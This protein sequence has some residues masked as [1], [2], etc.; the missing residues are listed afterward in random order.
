MVAQS[1]PTVADT[2]ICEFTV[3]VAWSWVKKA[4][5]FHSLRLFVLAR[6]GMHTSVMRKIMSLSPGLFGAF[7]VDG[8]KH[9]DFLAILILI[10][11]DK[12]H[13]GNLLLGVICKL[14]LF[15]WR[16]KFRETLEPIVLI[17]ESN[18]VPLAF[19]FWDTLNYDIFVAVTKRYILF[20]PLLIFPDCL[21]RP[22]VH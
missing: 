16:N 11:I 12:F 10:L 20:C 13:A 14:D 19:F 4:L 1:L 21:L 17:S 5:W 18:T 8:I 7:L 22:F 6:I 9:W 2:L 3:R 15:S